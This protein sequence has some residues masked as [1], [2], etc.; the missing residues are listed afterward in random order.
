MRTV[1]GSSD[2]WSRLW[3][4]KESRQKRKKQQR[5]RPK[6]KQNPLRRLGFASYEEYLA[7]DLWRTIRGRILE[8]DG[9]LCQ[10]CGK[11]A[12][13]VHHKNYDRPVLEG[14]QDFQLV[15]LCHVCH[16]SFEF[17]VVNGKPVKNGLKE[18]NQ[19]L[20]AKRMAYVKTLVFIAV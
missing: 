9:N 18:A 1:R 8:R 2:A 17:N 4:R 16:E 19:K 14:K 5:N 3:A 10:T 12:E 11:P 6:H 7:S 13:V 15:S 20:K